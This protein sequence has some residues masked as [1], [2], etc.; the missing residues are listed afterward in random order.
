MVEGLVGLEFDIVG[1]IVQSVGTAADIV[2]TVVD[3]AVHTVLGRLVGFADIGADF[4]DIVDY[5]AVGIV[6]TL[7]GSQEVAH[8][9]L[10]VIDLE[11][12]HLENQNNSEGLLDS[13][14]GKT[15]RN[16]IPLAH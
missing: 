5:T 14:L 4:E 1:W 3:T 16:Y 9:Y 10:A 13:R 6:D 8:N 7:F 11:E 15:L 2:D 12:A